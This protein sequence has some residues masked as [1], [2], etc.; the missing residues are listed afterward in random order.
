MRLT[1]AL[2]VWLIAEAIRKRRSGFND[3]LSLVLV[4]LLDRLS[5]IEV[6][7]CPL[8]G[9]AQARGGLPFVM[10]QLAIVRRQLSHDF[11]RPRSCACAAEWK[12]FMYSFKRVE[13]Q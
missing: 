7:N 8:L 5:G 13:V 4:S 10:S 6:S 1:G 12:L 9:P 2:P 3:V 11:G